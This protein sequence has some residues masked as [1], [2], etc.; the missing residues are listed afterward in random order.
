MNFKVW[1][2]SLIL[3]ISTV[4]CIRQ[5]S[6]P[7][8]WW[9]LRTGEYI[10]EHHTVPHT[11]VFSYTYNGDPWF[12]VKWA[13]EV[14]MAVVA[15]ILKPEFLMLLQYL[16]LLGVLLLIY[17]IYR[18]LS[19][20]MFGSKWPPGIGFYLAL[21]I[22]LVGISYRLN[23]RPEMMS[24]LM[25]C[26]YLYMF[27]HYYNHRSRLI[28]LLIPLQLI[29]ANLHE[30]FGVG[31]VLI[32]IFNAVVWFEHLSLKKLKTRFSKKQ[33]YL[34]G[35]VSIIC[36]FV[37]AIHPMGASMLLQ[38]LDIFGQLRENKFTTE[39]WS[40]QHEEYWNLPAYVAVF[41]FLAVLRFLLV[42][43]KPRRNLFVVPNFYLWM[44]LAFS[45]L[46]VSAHRN[47]PFFL[48]TAIP[49][50]AIYLQQVIPLNRYSKLSFAALGGSVCIM[51]SSGM[52]YKAFLP[53]ESYG[54]KIDAK[55]TPIGA[56][57]FIE[58]NQISGPA[59][60]DYF[61]S[62]FL[63]W[64]LQPDFKTY[65]DLR[66]LDLFEAN[67]IANNLLAHTRPQTPTKTGKPLFELMDDL[68]TF[69]YVLM[70]NNVKFAEF[71]RYM[72]R[73]AEYS[74]VYADPLSSV[75][76][77]RTVG[78]RPLLEQYAGKSLEELYHSHA[79]IEASPA[80]KTISLLFWPFYK[81]GQGTA[82]LEELRQIYRQQFIRRNPFMH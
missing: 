42:R 69:N 18:Q 36:L 76:V 66:D 60:V 53:R 21:V 55:S 56:A 74:F 3:L 27:L 28:F 54:L 25:T 61:S 9:Q 79:H 33:L 48:F 11:D 68:D 50:T 72:H 52:F 58:E 35:I 80:A 32:V 40:F 24:H 47:I 6:E 2:S 8:V 64:Y 38:P 43:R 70:G 41:L 82:D 4:L 67:F 78:N 23:A 59:Y 45:Y 20:V 22:F 10:L 63:L 81:A 39:L 16:V 19:L 29:W 37:P 75:Y 49:L 7:D 34:L 51:V 17:G 44:F 73:H 1:S 13:S 12:N 77:K 65:V 14:L 62:S 71:H 57:R 26:A 30:A 31:L 46:A 15:D 5:L